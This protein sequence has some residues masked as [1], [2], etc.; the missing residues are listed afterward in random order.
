[1]TID[2]LPEVAL[3]KIFDFHANEDEEQIEAWHTLVHVCRKW[4]NIV[5]A[6]PCRLDLRC[7]NTSEGNTG[8]LATLAHRHKG[9]LSPRNGNVGHG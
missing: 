2:M 5:F 6:S 8:C 4:R 7:Q 1:V 9:P 3:L